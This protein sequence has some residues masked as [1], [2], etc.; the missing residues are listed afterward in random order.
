[1]ELN[2]QDRKNAFSQSYLRYLETLEAEPGAKTDHDRDTVVDVFK[3]LFV[4]VGGQP[5]FR[6]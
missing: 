2:Y 5:H 6:A 4:I 3:Q 1:M